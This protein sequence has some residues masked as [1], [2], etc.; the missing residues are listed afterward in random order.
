MNGILETGISKV[1][2]VNHYSIGEGSIS[3]LPLELSRLRKKS[4]GKALYLVDEFFESNMEKLGDLGFIDEDFIIYIQ[5][6]E[7][8][9]TQYVNDIYQTL[10]EEFPGEPCVVVGIGGGI[11]MDCA[12]AISNLYTNGGKAEDYQGWDLL[13]KPGV[14]KIGIPTIS[15][16][17]AEATRT[18][19]M[20]NK[21]NGL[22]L[23]MNSD[24]SVFD[25]VIMDPKLSSTVPRN[26]FFYTGMDAYIHCI[27]S[28][29]GLHKNHIGRAFARETI[30]LCEEVFLSEDM[31]S[32]EN[33]I[34]LMTASYLGGC[35]IATSYVGLIHPFSAGLSV[36]LDIHHCEANCIVMRGM[37]EFYPK[38]FDV[39]WQ[40]AH[41][42]NIQIPSGITK[43]LNN[44][45]FDQLYD[46][47]II[48]E[49]PL[50][51]ALGDKFKE[52]LTRGKVKEIYE[53]M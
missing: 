33:R 28:I 8:P 53:L 44:H 14:Y 30:N 37:K 52:L 34:K 47:M 25:R 46:S 51:N 27:E 50:F 40:M 36:V 21:A 15:G 35:S 19:V 13:S 32:D 41:K 48:H 43:S 49:K 17:G 23:G 12:K 45:Q 22:K 31:M 24:Y 10:I 4:N 6:K 26:Q 1:H 39:F 42:Q 9:T 7:E 38:E 11:T 5:T 16:T 18:C 2:N 20:T 3:E 29:N